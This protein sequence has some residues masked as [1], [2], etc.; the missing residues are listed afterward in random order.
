MATAVATPATS[1]CK[2]QKSVDWYLIFHSVA[3]KNNLGN[4]LRSC[5]AFRVKAVLCVGRKKNVSFFGSKGTKSHV[6]L[7]FLKTLAEARQFCV[8]RQV[9]V[10]GVEIMKE[11][12]RGEPMLVFHATT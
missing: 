10:C 9:H 11:A 5:A 3:K 6:Q 1:S 4:I 7:I 12:E 8:E 2:P